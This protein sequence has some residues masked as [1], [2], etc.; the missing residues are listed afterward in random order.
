MKDIRVP[1]EYASDKLSVLHGLKCDD[2]SL[3]DQGQRDEVDINTRVKRFGLT[4]TVPVLER[5]PVNA[6]FVPVTDYKT[7]MDQLI[8]ADAA[9]M[10]LP[11][12][13][14]SKFNHDAGAFV[15]FCSDP[16]NSEELVKLGLAEKKV[17]PQPVLVRLAE[18]LEPKKEAPPAK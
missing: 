5:L 6:D 12:D 1:G 18:P 16:K 8:A 13:L 14:R 11:A 10:E 4:G 17:K 3:A 2:P 9:F 15:A 7:A